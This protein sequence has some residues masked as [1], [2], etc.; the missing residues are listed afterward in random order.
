MPFDVARL[1]NIELINIARS[2]LLMCAKSR[3]YSVSELNEEIQKIIKNSIIRNAA[4][5][6][7][8]IDMA[9]YIRKERY[10]LIAENIQQTVKK[11][12]WKDRL[13]RILYSI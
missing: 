11:D 1:M 4:E 9:E 6:V 5:N 8:N 13:K 2:Y 10:D 12:K 3:K 7:E